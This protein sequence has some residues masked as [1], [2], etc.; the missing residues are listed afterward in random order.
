MPEWMPENPYPKSNSIPLGETSQRYLAYK[1]GC[2]QTARKLVEWLGQ[3]CT[4]HCA[5]PE[6][7]KRRCYCS[8]CMEQLRKEVGLDK[9]R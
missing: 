6:K 5:Y 7:Y 9:E 3:G 8:A 4:T 2:Q 1:D